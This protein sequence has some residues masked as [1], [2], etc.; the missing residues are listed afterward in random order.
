MIYQIEAF[1]TSATVGSSLNLE[2]WFAIHHYHYHQYHV[3]FRVRNMIL[4][5]S[6]YVLQGERERGGE[7]CTTFNK[8]SCNIS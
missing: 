3:S 4:M 7:K 8:K 2:I 5:I 6:V 1:I